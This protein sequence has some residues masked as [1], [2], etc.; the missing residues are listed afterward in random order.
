MIKNKKFALILIAHADDETLGAGG[1]ILGG[2]GG[3]F[4]GAGGTTGADYFF[5][6]S[7][8]FF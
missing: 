4:G 1:T 8:G 6:S 3:A 7:F 5:S 2:A